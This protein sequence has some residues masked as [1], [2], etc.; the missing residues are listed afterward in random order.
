MTKTL[1]QYL[2]ESTR[3]YTYRIKVAGEMPTEVYDKLKA[4]LDSFHVVSCTKPK[5]S[6][7]QSS[8]AGFPGLSNLEVSVFEVTLEYP[9]SQDAIVQLARVAG[10]EQNNIIVID[11]DFDDSMEKEREGT[12]AGETRLEK[13]E[14]PTNT[15]E[16]NNAK[17]EYADSYQEAAATFASE[18]E[19]DFEVAGGKTAPAKYT[20]DAKEG[21]DSPMTKVKRLSIKDILK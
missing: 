10:I 17:D 14:Y 13:E 7:I 1:N 11:A 2:T 20:T 4:A 12:E 9:T 15:E 5:S 8:P 6:P 16:Q 3:E 19:T 18:A 21:T